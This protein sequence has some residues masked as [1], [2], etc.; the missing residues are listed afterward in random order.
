MAA[1]ASI[2][3]VKTIPWRGDTQEWS[4][5]YHFSASAP[6]DNTKWTT[7][8]DAVITAEKHIYRTGIEIVHTFGYEGGSET[9]VFEKS[10]ATVGD[11]GAADSFP[12][13]SEVVALAR[14]TTDKRSSK[15]H[16]VYLFNY[17]H[18]A[19]TKTP[20]E[21]DELLE[22]QKTAINTYMAAWVTGFSDGTTTHH[23]TGPDE[24]LATGGAAEQYVT[25]RDFR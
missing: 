11:L 3:V 23:R 9:A 10:Y 16:P 24:T 8:S 7:L 17:Y 15:N 6:T 21:I 20:G 4:N 22:L 12:Q 2:K 14:W 25:H 13:A 18:G 19:F 5:K 1:A